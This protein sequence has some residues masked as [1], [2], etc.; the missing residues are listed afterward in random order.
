VTDLKW[1]HDEGG[2]DW[3]AIKEETLSRIR[4]R[5]FTIEVPTPNVIVE[6][7]LGE[8]EGCEEY[9]EQSRA[10]DLALKSAEVELAVAKARMAA[11][12]ADR[13]EARVAANEL[14]DPT[15]NE[16]GGI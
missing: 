1:L 7:R 5:R 15:P 8:C 10:N 3:R 11:A 6:P 13:Y 9:I 4:A 16:P 2:I 14:D 12:E